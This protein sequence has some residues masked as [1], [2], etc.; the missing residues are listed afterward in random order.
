MALYHV[1]CRDH[2]IKVSDCDSLLPTADQ[3][4]DRTQGR[5]AVVGNGCQA[6]SGLGSWYLPK[7]ISLHPQA[8]HITYQAPQ[9][10]GHL[11]GVPHQPSGW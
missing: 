1:T 4:W 10:P 3:T 9:T 7:P 6:G 8:H 5:R 2:L 11:A